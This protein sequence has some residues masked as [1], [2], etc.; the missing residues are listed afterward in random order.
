MPYCATTEPKS[1][2]YTIK[3]SLTFYLFYLHT[4]MVQYIEI[5]KKPGTS[6]MCQAINSCYLP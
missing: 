2:V 3:L 1:N 6:I 5:Y 4:S